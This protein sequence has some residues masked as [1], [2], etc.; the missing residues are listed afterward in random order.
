M[1]FYA[2]LDEPEEETEES[3]QIKKK[4]VNFFFTFCKLIKINN[5]KVK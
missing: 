1:D 4:K 2:F 3:N 5:G